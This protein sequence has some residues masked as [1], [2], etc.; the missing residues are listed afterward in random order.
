MNIILKLF[1][2]CLIILNCL[3]VKL[4]ENIEKSIKRSINSF[5]KTIFD[6]NQN[7][8]KIQKNTAPNKI[9]I[10]NKFADLENVQYL[11]SDN[12]EPDSK[13]M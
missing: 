4:A 5:T 7:T 11:K 8:I 6:T 10:I 1:F 13:G 2:I 9:K 12:Q 3:N